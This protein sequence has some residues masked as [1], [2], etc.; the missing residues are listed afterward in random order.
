VGLVR[1]DTI[2]IQP[3]CDTL[4]DSHTCSGGRH[5]FLPA[6]GFLSQLELK[7]RTDYLQVARQFV[8]TYPQRGLLVIISDFLDDHEI[9]RPLQLLAEFGHELMLV[10]VWSPEDRVPPWDGELELIDSE[11]GTRLEMAV[12]DESR[13]EYTAA[14]DQ[15]AKRLQSLS[16]RHGGR[17][18]GLS[19]DT[20]VEEAVF[21]ALMRVG[22]VQ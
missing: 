2:R 18:V 4:S 15:Y 6:V 19:S 14:F 16:Q 5:R 8:G 22:G 9:E 21:G 20:P 10:H 11:T 7:G 1:L 3:F 12:D 17:Y 13:A